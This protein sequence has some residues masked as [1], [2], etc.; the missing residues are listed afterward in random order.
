MPPRGRP[1]SRRPQDEEVVK[2]EDPPIEENDSESGEE[3]EDEND[4]ETDDDGDDGDGDDDADED[5]EDGDDDEDEESEEEVIERRVLPARANRGSKMADL[6]AKADD[7][8]SEFWQANKEVFAEDE[9]DSDF[10]ASGK[11]YF[12][13]RFCISSCETIRDRDG[14]LSPC[15]LLLTH[16]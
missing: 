6:M 12:L 3:D 7:E 5:D 13:L 2:M 4:E 11:Y 15:A 8:T 16:Y 14:V 10:E 1:R 9:V